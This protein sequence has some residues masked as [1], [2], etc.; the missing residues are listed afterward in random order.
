[1]RDL[2]L[3]GLPILDALEV[4]AST[5]MAA[6]W[7]NCDQSS[8]SRTYRQASQQLG[9][10]FQK[11]NGTY[12]ASGN[13]D[14]LNS[15]RQASQLRRLSSQGHLLQWVLHPEVSVLLPL[16]LLRPWIK[17]PLAC[18]WPQPFR[19]VDLLQ[20]RLVDL[21]LIP[22][23][24][25]PELIDQGPV[26]VM[27]MPLAADTTATDLR[28]AAVVHPDLHGHP[29]IDQVLEELQSLLM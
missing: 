17:A 13:L 11:H 1:M 3:D 19:L 14:L 7:L 5:A 29:C 26:A 6:R 21:A 23:A 2:F 20:R 8:I 4:G 24:L 22:E 18:H 25:G 10:N 12:N 27:V 15:L 28:P 9:L 16:N